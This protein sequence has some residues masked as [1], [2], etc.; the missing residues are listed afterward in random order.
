MYQS[1]A[2]CRLKLLIACRGQQLSLSHT[3]HF[4]LNIH[5]EITHPWSVHLYAIFWCHNLTDKLEKFDP[6][7]RR[8]AM[9]RSLFKI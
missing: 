6:G 9:T 8:P 4:K 7:Q 1:D 3:Y 5:P 2:E